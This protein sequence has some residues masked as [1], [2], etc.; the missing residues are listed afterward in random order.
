MKNR[1]SRMLGSRPDKNI[2]YSPPELG[3]TIKISF[4]LHEPKEI[5]SEILSGKKRGLLVVDGN[6]DENKINLILFLVKKYVEEV[7]VYK[8]KYGEKN[9]NRVKQIWQSMIRFHP[10]VAIALG[11]GTTCDLVG[12]ASSCY[13]RNLDHIFFP[14][15]LLSMVDACVGGKTGI[16]FGGIKNSVGQIHYALESYCIFPFLQSLDYGELISGFSEV[17]KVGMLF[18]GDL[19][20]QIEKLPKTFSFSRD[21][22]SAISRGAELKAIMSENQFS[23]RSKLLY[24]HNIGHGLETLS[25][26]HRR[27]GDCVSIGINYELAIAVVVGKVEKN[28]WERQQEILKSFGLPFKIPERANFEKI[29]SKMRKYKLYREGRY[30]FVF[31]KNPGEIIETNNNFYTEL[32]DEKLD[33]AYLEA[34][35]LILQ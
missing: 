8:L 7:E 24:G 32:P 30:L 21:W 16:D 5:Q 10:D 6:L 13:H 19:I 27:H 23:Q 15:T 25:S 14:T 28:I 33:K 31:P 4:F 1:N 9:L 18:D 29:K 12:F 35:K 11:G 20:Q 34:K 2:L 26:T 17:V 3:K 22:F